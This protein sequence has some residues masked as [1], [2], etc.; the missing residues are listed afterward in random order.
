MRI[1]A[2]VLTTSAYFTTTAKRCTAPKYT[3]LTAH[4]KVIQD[5]P[6]CAAR[7]AN[8]WRILKALLKSV[9][10]LTQG[11]KECARKHDRS[12]PYYWQIIPF[13]MK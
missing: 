3:I 13:I 12:T 7:V 2:T 1:A 9:Q 4:G 5:K 6:P 11:T 8:V 10:R